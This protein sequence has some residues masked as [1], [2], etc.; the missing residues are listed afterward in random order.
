MLVTIVVGCSF[1][2][3]QTST[4]N[5]A[6]KGDPDEEAIKQLERDWDIADTKGDTAALDRIL[7][8]DYVQV[9]LNGVLETK[10]SG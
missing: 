10:A 7:A 2:N 4:A 1:A 6:K 5:S 3:G 8:S 9:N